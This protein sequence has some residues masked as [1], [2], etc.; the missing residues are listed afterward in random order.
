MKVIPKTQEVYKNVGKIYMFKRTLEAL[1][2]EG[3]IPDG[4]L[5]PVWFHLGRSM[6]WR[7]DISV[8]AVGKTHRS[9]AE[10]AEEWQYQ[11][12]VQTIFDSKFNIRVGVMK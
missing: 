7:D 2:M 6:M 8:E 3:F 11:R 12:L 10:E 1:P 9:H 4:T 5:N